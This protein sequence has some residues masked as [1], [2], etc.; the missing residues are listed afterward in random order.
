M[1]TKPDLWIYG[2]LRELI[3]WKHVLKFEEVPSEWVYMI[4]DYWRSCLQSAIFPL[5]KR[6]LFMFFILFFPF[7]VV[8]VY[9]QFLVW[10]WL[11]KSI[12]RLIWIAVWKQERRHVHASPLRT[13]LFFFIPCVYLY[14]FLFFHLIFLY[15][16]CLST[17]LTY[18]HKWTKIC[19]D[20]NQITL[21]RI[22]FRFTISLIYKLDINNYKVVIARIKIGNIYK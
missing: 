4:Y 19:R 21:I 17:E 12:E 20:D 6:V 22:G 14:T 18:G 3:N 5:F 11:E 7:T 2:E 15:S 9:M 8:A 1:A 10:L 13:S 16:M